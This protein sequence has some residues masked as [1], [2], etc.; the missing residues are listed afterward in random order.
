MNPAFKCSSVLTFTASHTQP[1]FGTFP[2]HK[3]THH[4][5]TETRRRGSRKSDNSN[6]LFVYLED[7][8]QGSLIS[9]L[10][11][12]FI[13]EKSEGDSHGVN[14]PRHHARRGNIAIDPLGHPRS[15]SVHFLSPLSPPT[16]LREFGSVPNLLRDRPEFTQLSLWHGVARRAKTAPSLR[17]SVV[18]LLMHRK[19]LECRLSMG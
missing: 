9:D 14:P 12:Q 15:H 7:S 2:L 8:L 13:W 4:G 17:A 19:S 18:S 5:G 1:T 11:K 16:P 6:I 10:R 3:R